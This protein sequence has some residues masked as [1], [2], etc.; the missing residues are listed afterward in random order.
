MTDG[1]GSGT[2]FTISGGVGSIQYVMGEI[3]EAGV[4]LARLA[5]QLA[6]LVDRLRSEWQWLGGAAQ[7][8]PG[9]YQALDAMRAAVWSAMHAQGDAADLGAEAANASRNY[10]DAEA[11][12]ASLAAQLARMGA[13][14]AGFQVWASGPL[15]PLVFW[16]EVV[17]GG[18]DAR[19]HGLRDAAESGLNNGPA[20]LAGLLGPGTALAYLLTHLGAPD[21]ANAGVGPALVMR[22]FLDAS[23][24]SRPG[25]LEMRRVP[26]VDWDDRAEQWSPGHAVPDPTGGVPGSVDSTISGVLAGSRDAYGYPPGSI[27]VSLVERPDGSHAWIVNLPGTEDWSVVDS[28]NNWDLEG[29]MEA[30]TAAQ[31]GAFAQRNIIIQDL[32]KGALRDAGALPTDEVMITG[33][34]GGGIH[35]A[36]AAAD[37]AFLAEVNVTM[38]I[39]AGAPNKNQHIAPGIDVLDMENTND[40]A[41]AAD[42]GPAPASSTWVAVTSHRPGDSNRLNPI[43]AAGG[44]HDLD[45]YLE[46]AAELDRSNDPAIRGSRDAVNKFLAPAVAGGPVTVKKFVYQGHDVNDPVPARRKLAPP[47]GKEVHGAR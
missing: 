1:D 43:K 2:T 9:S 20:F 32:I 23:G 10:D 12:N 21:A 24:M 16:S 36:A 7:G 29:D 40:I 28:D 46:D 38:I 4:K 47:S 18:H 14:G 6:P 44:A 22:K 19:R 5:Q 13:L 3:S 41:T 25:H 26:A 11:R 30:M 39:I 33:H 35:A 27:G 15:A 17:A 37:P 42:Y 34:S 8:L 31:A 45:N